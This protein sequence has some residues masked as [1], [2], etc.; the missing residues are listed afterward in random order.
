MTLPATPTVGTWNEGSRIWAFLVR[1]AYALRGCLTHPLLSLSSQSNSN[2]SGLPTESAVI[3]RVWDPERFCWSKA[4]IRNCQTPAGSPGATR[5]SVLKLQ[6][7]APGLQ[8]T[9]WGLKTSLCTRVPSGLKVSSSTNWVERAPPG[10]L[11]CTVKGRCGG[12]YAPRGRRID[13]GNG[14][15]LGWDDNRSARATTAVAAGGQ[16]PWLERPVANKS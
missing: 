7:V 9:C 14:W 3:R 5:K 15:A 8:P 1:R 16:T 10:T 4:V 12:A 13:K 11:T 6:K 2:G